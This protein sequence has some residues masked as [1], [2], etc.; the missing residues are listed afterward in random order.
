MA[1]QQRQKPKAGDATGRQ[2]A[3]LEAE[4][5]EALAKR[6]EEMTMVNQQVIVE[7]QNAVFDPKSGEKVAESDEDAGAPAVESKDG[8]VVDLGVET[9]ESDEVVIRVN[10]TLTN[11]TIGAGTFFNFDEGKKY[12][13]P[14]HVARHLEEKGYL[15]H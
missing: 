4:Q 12:K 1:T 7:T 10:E 15:W 11:V 8:E 2:K 9:V 3:A 14:R 5:A 13:V 6:Q